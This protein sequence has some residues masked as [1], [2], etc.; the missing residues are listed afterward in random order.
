PHCERLLPP[1]FFL[2]G[3]EMAK[4]RPHTGIFMLHDFPRGIT[5]KGR[6]ESRISGLNN[7][8]LLERVV[9]DCFVCHRPLTGSE[10][11]S[12]DTNE[13]IFPQWL[14]RH[15]DL[16]DRMINLLDKTVSRAR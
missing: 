15:F 2:R 9:S 13:D 8:E 6:S 14:Q 5:I 16:E 3:L 7:Q 1:L 12:K 11:A 4:K 10:Q